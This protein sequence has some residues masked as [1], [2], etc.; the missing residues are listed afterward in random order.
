MDERALKSYFQKKKTLKI[1]NII[2][3][4]KY[5][6]IFLTNRIE[7]MIKVD[8]ALNVCILYK[9]VTNFI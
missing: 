8:G 3:A 1:L 4:S 5:N 6:E 2:E 7:K 9:I